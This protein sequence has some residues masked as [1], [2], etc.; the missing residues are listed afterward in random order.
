[1]V[2]LNK[3]DCIKKIIQMMINNK[4][5]LYKKFINKHNIIKMIYL[6]M[7]KIYQIFGKKDVKIYKKLHNKQGFYQKKELRANVNIV[8]VIGVLERN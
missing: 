4:G 3:K 2:K 8:V 7:Q 1:M 6:K 5:D